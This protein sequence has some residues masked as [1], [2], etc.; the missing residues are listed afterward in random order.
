MPI[1][2]VCSTKHFHISLCTA[3]VSVAV[4]SGGK[5]SKMRLTR[6]AAGYAMGEKLLMF[7]V[8]KSVKPCCFSGVKSLPCFYRVQKHIWMDGDLFT[9]WVKELDE[10]FASQ[11]RKVALIINNCPAHSKFDVLK[12]LELIFLPPNTTSKTQPMNQGVIRSL[13]AYYY[14]SLIKSY[15]TSIGGRRLP[16]NINM[17]EAMTLFTAAWECVSQETL[18][19]CIKKA[20][21][22]SENQA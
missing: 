19:N 11:D 22:S 16:T 4:C 21:I 8:G 6:L 15:I 17:F 3:R 13:K 2:L 12:T 1:N 5:Y 20:G 18:V 10:E 9:K 14:H 7:V